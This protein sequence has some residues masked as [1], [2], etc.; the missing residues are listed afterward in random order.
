MSS[1]M[2]ILVGVALIVLLT[3][4]VVA[5]FLASR[6]AAESAEKLTDDAL[7]AATTDAQEQAAAR[8]VA[9]AI[10]THGTGTRNVVQP[11]LV[12]LL[13][14][15]TNPPVRSAAMRGLATIWDYD[16]MP[17]MLD[18]LNDPSPQVRSSAAMAAARLVESTTDFDASAP[19]EK[20]APSAKKLR[21]NWE[22]FKTRTLK[23][24]Q[25]RLAEKDKSDP[26]NPKGG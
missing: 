3:G 26:T 10:K 15:S 5:R 25:Q 11:N 20:R 13:N 16:C 24:W 6:P 2:R 19:P 7:H 14:E 17:Q 22:N 1:Q 18:S 9:L 23:S 8:L 4:G 21:D 12:R